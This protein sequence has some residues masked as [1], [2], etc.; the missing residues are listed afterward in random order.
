[1]YYSLLG[2]KYEKY[3]LWRLLTRKKNDARAYLRACGTGFEKS[4]KWP[5]IIGKSEPKR[6]G[7]WLKVFFFN[8]EFLII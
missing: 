4:V 3:G 5:R 8:E 6:S 1:M 2:M 7:F